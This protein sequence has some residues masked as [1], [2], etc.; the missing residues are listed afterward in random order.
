MMY[1]LVR[2]QASIFRSRRFKHFS[3]GFILSYPQGGA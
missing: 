1:A 3:G 2:D